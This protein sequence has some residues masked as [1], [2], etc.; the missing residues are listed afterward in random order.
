[1]QATSM[2]T[3]QRPVPTLTDETPPPKLRRLNLMLCQPQTA[4]IDTLI[5]ACREHNPVPAELVSWCFGG[6]RMSGATLFINRGAPVVQHPELVLYS[7]DQEVKKHH[8]TVLA[9]LQSKGGSYAEWI[10][11]T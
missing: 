7:V 5:A 4:A 8:G 11:R 3:R 6:K 1:M 2:A 10:M 9:V